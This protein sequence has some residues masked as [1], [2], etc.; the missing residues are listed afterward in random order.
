MLYPEQ[1]Q[2]TLDS[3]LADLPSHDFQVPA[4]TLGQVVSHAFQTHPELP[5]VMIISDEQPPGIISRRKFFEWLSR[6]YGLEIY[7][8][9]PMSVLWNTIQTVEIKSGI[10]SPPLHLPASCKIHKAVDIALARDPHQAY[11]PIALVLPD[12][13]VRFLD[14]HILLVAHSRLFQL[15]NQT[16]EE[17]KDAAIAANRAKSQ[18]LA[19]MS[20]ELRTPLNAIL[21][22]SEMLQEDAE[23]MG[24]QDLSLDL[25]KIHGAG[26]H[27][28]GIINDILDLSKIEA[29]RMELYLEP[30]DIEPTLEEVVST[31]EPLIEKNGNA[32]A[33]RFAPE[34]GSMWADLT[35]VRQNLFNL[36]SNAAKFT[37]NGTISLEVTR[38]PNPQPQDSAD[39]VLCA[40]LAQ[41]PDTGYLTPG[42][43]H[44]ESDWICFKIKDT[45]IG[46]TPEQINRLFEAFT[47][48]DASTTRKYGGTGLGLAIAKRFCEMM[49]GDITVTSREGEGSTFTMLLPAQV[50]TLPNLEQDCSSTADLDALPETAKMV[51][52]IDDDPTVHEL[53]Q[54]FLRKEGWG[55]AVAST[56]DRGLELAKELHPDAITLDVM[57]PHQDGWS[58]LC[59]LKAD[60]ELADIPTI[61]LTMMDNK[62][63]G[64]ALGASDYMTKPIDRH[65][66]IALLHKYQ[67]RQEESSPETGPVESILIV[68]DDPAT[69]ELLKRV[70]E[71]H[72]WKTLVAENGRRGLEAI[73]AHP[74]DL[75]L[76]DLMMPEMDGFEFLNALKQYPLWRSIPVV[77]MTA[78]DI[79]PQEYL[80]LKGSVQTILQK[81]GLSFDRLCTEIR[82][83]IAEA[84]QHQKVG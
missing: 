46:M 53:M 82:T 14:L 42:V 34:L 1:D 41:P 64:M 52:V 8:K 29:G 66:L 74:P 23:D 6:P 68:E 61:V 10:Y 62:P 2:L 57:M 80:Q 3:T 54:R 5:G 60:P 13:Q 77:V 51:L 58:V 30:F 71:N 36:L 27:L 47:Q 25:Q 20:H 38:I 63:M 11:E 79:T 26:K 17:K 24:Q 16:I 31:I 28:L 83:M 18:F 39:A 65:R 15:A 40:V 33:V 4:S 35:K 50:K 45:G 75:I 69:R 78:K 9:R 84:C 49:G 73:A 12:G 21:G 81:Q 55:V 32:I 44:S 37:E 67:Q 56:G 72:G 48:A 76:L 70:L 22:Y 59:A 7:L 43:P 19:N